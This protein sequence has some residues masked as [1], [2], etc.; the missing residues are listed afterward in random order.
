MKEADYVQRTINRLNQEFSPFKDDDSRDPAF[1]RDMWNYYTQKT[2]LENVFTKKNMDKNPEKVHAVLKRM[3][4]GEEHPDAQTLID[5]AEGEGDDQK[6]KDYFIK[7][8][9][10]RKF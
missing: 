1:V 6:V 9:H 2:N 4:L 5:L 7:T 3:Q 8:L 10:K